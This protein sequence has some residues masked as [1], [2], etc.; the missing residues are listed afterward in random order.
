MGIP[1]TTRRKVPLKLTGDLHLVNLTYTEADLLGWTE[2][3][4]L[5]RF[6]LH[7]GHAY[8]C[9]NGQYDRGLAARGIS[10]GGHGLVAGEGVARMDVLTTC[11]ECG[12]SV[13]EFVEL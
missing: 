11:R 5:R 2:N 10:T 1:G 12:T 3:V 4:K 13:T 6:G 9:P 8:G 7:A